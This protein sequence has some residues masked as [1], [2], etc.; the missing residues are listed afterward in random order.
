MAPV[1]EATDFRG[2]GPAATAIMQDAGV[3]PWLLA[4]SLLLIVRVTLAA[5]TDLA[6]DEAYYWLWSKS[7]VASYYDHP[8]MI[9]YWIRAGT[10]LFG[11]TAFGVRVAGLMATL[12]GSYLLYLTSLSLFRNRAAGLMAVFWLNA[13]LLFN[14]AA[15]VATPDTPLAFFTTVALFAFA[16]LIETGRGAWWVASTR[17]GA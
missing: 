6:E 10:S 4:L 12:A 1:R 7:L 5:S 9:A 17:A 14:A 15:I 16:K 2:Q 8:P 3:Y 13:T 11:Q